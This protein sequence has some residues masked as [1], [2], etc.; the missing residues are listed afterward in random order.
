MSNPTRK[1]TSEQ[2]RASIIRAVRHLFA[3][4]GFKG[5][6]T[7][8][9]AEAAGVSEALVYRHFPTKEALF[10][11]IQ[12]SFCDDQARA[13]FDRINALEPGTR[14]LVLLAH[15]MARQVLG[16]TMEWSE[17]ADQ[18]RMILRSLAEDGELARSL[19]EPMAAVHAPKI[20]DCLK[21]AIA[22]GDAVS[23][24]V[25]AGLAGWLVYS[26]GAMVSF[27]RT[28]DGPV[29]G[30][31]L[32]PA[33]MAAQVTWFVLRGLGLREEAIKRHYRPDRLPD[34]EA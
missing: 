22:A 5:V 4:K 7:R 23:G 34:L 16:A 13:R 12:Q 3:N 20:R 18:N 10:D 31:E 11:A 28:P 2:R 9:V 25:D 27:L 1:L 24:P 19:L 26:L 17:R 14:T 21:A 6:R 8:E 32:D 29:L 33:A 30:R 15:H